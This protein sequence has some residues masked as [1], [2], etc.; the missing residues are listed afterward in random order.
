MNIKEIIPVIDPH[1]RRH[2]M[3]I[4]NDAVRRKDDKDTF[5]VKLFKSF[6]NFLIFHFKLI[7]RNYRIIFI[8]DKVF[9]IFFLNDFLQLGDMVNHSGR[10]EKFIVEQQVISYL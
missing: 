1:L 6:M 3:L 8:Q 5:I 9:D 2:V 4:N 7:D 10:S